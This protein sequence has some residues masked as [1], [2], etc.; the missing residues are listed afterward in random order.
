M[1][2]N[3]K[4]WVA[5]VGGFF[6]TVLE[7]CALG[8]LLGAVF[9]PWLG[10]TY[11]WQLSA[12]DLLLLGFRY[13]GETGGYIGLHVALVRLL[14]REGRSTAA[15]FL[16]DCFLGFYFT[17]L[18]LCALGALLGAVTFPV[19]GRLG[20]AHKTTAELV[21]FGAK[22]LG[23]YFMVW[24]PGLALVREFMRAAKQ[25]TEAKQRVAAKS[26]PTS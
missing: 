8:A 3:A 15:D 10:T 24:A 26:P 5:R 21:L 20:G 19:A 13:L 22:T 1:N 4:L 7:L 11:D 23:F 9:F 6:F 25:N 12:P 14:R 16:R 17:V 18:E 2:P